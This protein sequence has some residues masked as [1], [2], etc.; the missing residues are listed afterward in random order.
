MKE[1]GYKGEV[2]YVED[3]NACEIKVSDKVNSVS[4]TPNPTD[5]SVYRVSTVAGGWWWHT[6]TVEQSVQKACS[7]LI[8]HREKTSSQTACEELHEFVESLT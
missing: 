3:T 2:F 1:Y 8:D 7:V 6:N 5:A 4:I